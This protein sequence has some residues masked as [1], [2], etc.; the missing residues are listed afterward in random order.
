MFYVPLQ[1]MLGVGRESLVSMH[2]CW[3]CLSCSR[4]RSCSTAGEDAG[5][6]S[7]AA[8]AVVVAV[9]GARLAGPDGVGEVRESR[10]AAGFVLLSVRFAADVAAAGVVQG[11]R[12]ANR[13][14]RCCWLF[15][16]LGLCRSLLS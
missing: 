13:G 11:S 5:A 8:A 6:G 7:V 12:F 15:S 3:R 16:T 4:G 10:A 9:G 2:W 1:L 14:W